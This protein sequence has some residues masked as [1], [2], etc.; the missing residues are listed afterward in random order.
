MTEDSGK[1]AGRTGVTLAIGIA[2]DM[3]LY[4]VLLG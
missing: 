1:S 3:L 2:V 4:K